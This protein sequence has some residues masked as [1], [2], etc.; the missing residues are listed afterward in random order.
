MR[1][2]FGTILLAAGAASFFTMEGF[3]GTVTGSILVFIGI[4]LLFANG[5]SSGHGGYG[6]S[7]GGGFFIG[8][9]DGGDCGGGDGGCG[10]D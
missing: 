1:K 4:M 10:G 5:G 2:L 6:G 7:D 8:G 3:A 9:S